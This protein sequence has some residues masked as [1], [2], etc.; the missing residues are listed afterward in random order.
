[1]SQSSR[2]C[3]KTCPPMLST[4]SNGLERNCNCTK[5]TRFHN[6]YQLHP[7]TTMWG[8]RAQR[9]WV[10]RRLKPVSNTSR[11]L[12][13]FLLC[14]LFT[15]LIR[16]PQ[17]LCVLFIFQKM[18]KAATL[19]RYFTFQ[20]GHVITHSSR[21]EWHQRSHRLDHIIWQI[22]DVILIFIWSN[23]GALF[24]ATFP[25]QISFNQVQSKIHQQI[26]I[27]KG[28]YTKVAKSGNARAR[29]GQ[30]GMSCAM[31]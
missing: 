22:W 15:I 25:C 10:C 28:K 23:Q 5:K 14:L 19:F 8:T 2:Q 11:L 13:D 31:S 1:M 9:S 24:S 27:Q 21:Q 7:P 4:T 17:H 29:K 3:D 18:S 16:K 20:W 26:D 6:M 30:G 12:N